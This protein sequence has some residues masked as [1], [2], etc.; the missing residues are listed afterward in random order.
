MI[1]IRHLISLWVCFG[2]WVLDKR[3]LCKPNCHGERGGKYGNLV[4]SPRLRRSRCLGQTSS[5]HTRGS[6]G[7]L[8][9][10][11]DWDGDCRPRGSPHLDQGKARCAWKSSR[12]SQIGSDICVWRWYDRLEIRLILVA[13]QWVVRINRVW[14]GGHYFCCKCQ[15]V[16][17]CDLKMMTGTYGLI[18]FLSG[19][20][21]TQMTFPWTSMHHP[22]NIIE[23][24]MR[25]PT[26]TV[27]PHCWI[28]WSKQSC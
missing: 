24:L 19:M 23:V 11:L 13:S 4:L 20:W 17:R 27:P 18:C 2:R 7:T 25:D 16:W 6:R 14:I 10:G 3:Q 9:G 26:W 5:E 8:W 21:N 15:S 12:G 28:L 22:D 1:P